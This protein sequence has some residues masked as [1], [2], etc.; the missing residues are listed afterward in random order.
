MIGHGFITKQKTKQKNVVMS[1]WYRGVKNEN[2]YTARQKLRLTEI[3]K[4]STAFREIM[5]IK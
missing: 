4:N 3:K 1:C 2:Q 5:S